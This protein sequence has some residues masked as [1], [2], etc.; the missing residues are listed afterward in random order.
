SNS[1]YD[2][3]FIHGSKGSIR[4]D[5]EYNQAGE[6]SYKIYVEDTVTE[7]KVEVPNNYSLEI[8]NLSRCVLNNETP[9]VSAEFSLKNI[10]LMDSIL[11]KIGFWN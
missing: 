9:H 11:S 1:R 10:K 6:V 3:L 2:R 7:R 5:V 8:E 4:S